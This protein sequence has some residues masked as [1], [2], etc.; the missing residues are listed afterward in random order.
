MVDLKKKK[1]LVTGASG[2]I[3]RAICEMALE[4]GAQLIVTGSKLE[5]LEKLVDELDGEVKA[6]QCDLSESESISS[7]ISSVLSDF[8]DVDIL[9]NNAGVTSDSIFMRMGDEQW[10]KILAINLTAVMKLSRGF[11]RG[12]M[13]KRWGRIINLGS[14]IG[15]TGNPGQSNYAASKAGLIGMSKSLAHEVASRGITVNCISPGFIQTKMIQ[16]LSEVQKAG[17][18]DKIPVG[19]IGSVKEIA[20]TVLFLASSEASYITGQTIHVNGGM[21]MI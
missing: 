20:G 19:R 18:I 7:L 10:D 6:Y 13:K 5:L 15:T 1:V 17:I 8:G 12:M 9:V 2:G 11:V 3:G 4:A 16:N 21:A 14:I